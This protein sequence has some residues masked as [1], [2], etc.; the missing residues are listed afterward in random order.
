MK[1][2]N[3]L[4]KRLARVG[5]TA[6]ITKNHRKHRRNEERMTSACNINRTIYAPGERV[7]DNSSAKMS[8]FMQTAGGGNNFH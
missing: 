7:L 5:T 6:F 8:S 3:R 2:S 4:T 1:L